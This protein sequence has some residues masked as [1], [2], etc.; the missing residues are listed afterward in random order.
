MQSGHGT[1]TNQAAGPVDAPIGPIGPGSRQGQRKNRS[2]KYIIMATK[3]ERAGACGILALMCLMGALTSMYAIDRANSVKEARVVSRQVDLAEEYEK[4]TSAM[5]KNAELRVAE[6]GMAVEVSLS[7]T[8][9]PDWGV[10]RMAED[11]SLLWGATRRE[12]E[13]FSSVTFTP[14]LSDFL[15]HFGLWATVFH[16][17]RPAFEDLIKALTNDS[18]ACMTTHVS[19]WNAESGLMENIKMCAPNDT[20]YL[21]SYLSSPYILYAGHGAGDT[22]FG[23]RGTDIGTVIDPE[24]YRDVLW[25][26]ALGGVPIAGGGNSPFIGPTVSGDMSVVTTIVFPVS[27]NFKDL[28]NSNSIIEGPVEWPPPPAASNGSVGGAR[29][30][31]RST[32]HDRSSTLL[33]LLVSMRVSGFVSRLVDLKTMLG[34]ILV[35]QRGI[36]R[37]RML[38]TSGSNLEVLYDDRPETFSEHAP[39]VPILSP[40]ET[41]QSVLAE[42]PAHG[43][44]NTSF[45]GMPMAIVIYF[46]DPKEDSSVLVVTA[47]IAANL[48]FLLACSIV[49]ILKFRAKARLE[50]ERAERSALQRATD[51]VTTES[52]VTDQL[53]RVISHDIRTPAACI[54]GALE[55]LESMPHHRV[56]PREE[57][58]MYSVLRECAHVVSELAERFLDFSRMKMNSLV[59]EPRPNDIVEVVSNVVSICHAQARAKDVD[60]FFHA[61]GPGAV[62]VL[63]DLSRVRQVGL[64][65]VGNALKFTNPGGRV[66]VRLF[67]KR[68]P[69]NVEARMMVIDTGIGV[70]NNVEALFKPYNQGTTDHL[71]TD[72]RHKGIGLGLFIV[73]E[74]VTL[75]HGSVDCKR[76]DSGPGSTFCV[77]LPLPVAQK[78]DSLPADSAPSS[79]VPERAAS[80]SALVVDDTRSVR[81]VLV[82][83]LKR[84]NTFV[85]VDEAGTGAEAV[86]RVRE[87]AYDIIYMDLQMEPMDG[88]AT[89]VLIRDTHSE[90]RRRQAV[91]FAFTATYNPPLG[92]M[93]W[94]IPEVPESPDPLDVS[95]PSGRAPNCTPA[96]DG[97]I[98]KPF[99]REDIEQSLKVFSDKIP[100]A[101][102]ST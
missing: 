24:L 85:R 102:S 81:R 74:L 68:Y 97:H 36:T 70:P 47:C 55:E 9:P 35:H 38:S 39:T 4:M 31:G 8:P 52:R 73:K 86:A 22:V 40:Q 88:Y 83:H 32:L 72:V 90:M 53:L 75:M 20:V 48:A 41:V 12:H 45:A 80:L 46:E 33:D 44:I 1:E 2:L 93:L 6:W 99:S 37:V 21:A 61:P 58:D 66:D 96:F 76:N 98:P 56:M 95:V 16:D 51:R 62:W 67:L 57:R 13:V 30:P 27:L 84:T 11:S 3:T 34:G 77:R 5:L 92:S 14:P 101:A 29:V 19:R 91:I 100:S 87:V 49:F 79:V 25:R 15:G 23:D 54:V 71:S 28:N 65:L 78:P 64:N 59:L 10:E 7:G 17:D 50:R 18:S 42:A 69:D 89:A 63:A 26:S 82:A 43:V 60:L 94:T